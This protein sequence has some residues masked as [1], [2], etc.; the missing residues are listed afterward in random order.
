MTPSCESYLSMM[1]IRVLT[2][3]SGQW[4]HRTSR[5]ISRCGAF[6]WPSVSR[7]CTPMSGEHDIC[8][9]TGASPSLTVSRRRT[10]V[11]PG[12]ESP[13]KN[14]KPGQLDWVIIR[15]NSE[16]EY[17]G[18]G[19]RSHRQLDHEVGTGQRL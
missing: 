13:L 16:G 15:E 19:G 12:T 18:H 7:T 14:C 6:D 1:S 5:T 8:L 9:V 17:A 4:V 10:K 3:A 2:P 11:I